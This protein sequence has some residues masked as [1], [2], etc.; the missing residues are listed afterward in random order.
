MYRRY[1]KIIISLSYNYPA[2]SLLDALGFHSLLWTEYPI[3][4]LMVGRVGLEPTEP[5]GIWFT[6]R[7]ATCYGIPTHIKGWE[8]G[9]RTHKHVLLMQK[10]N[11]CLSP[12]RDCVYNAA[13]PIRLSPNIYSRLFPNT[14]SASA[15]EVFGAVTLLNHPK[16][17]IT[18]KS[19]PAGLSDTL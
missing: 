1:R 15:N 11:G 16:C 9:T 8:S 17:A 14:R 2:L 4:T 13:V 18:P 10:K 19:H 12:Y 7:T 3:L 5:Q 6:V